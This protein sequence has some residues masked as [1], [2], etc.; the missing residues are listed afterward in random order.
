MFILTCMMHTPGGGQTKF[1]L[2]YIPGDEQT[3]SY[4]A[5]GIANPKLWR[6]TRHREDA[7]VFVNRKAVN[8]GLATI[9]HLG[10]LEV[11][12]I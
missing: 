8:K 4:L 12:V 11:E 2:E 10:E 1:Y 7:R 6:M 9:R 3:K 5:S